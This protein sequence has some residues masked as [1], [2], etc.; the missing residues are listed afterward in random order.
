VTG[1]P[2]IAGTVG[3]KYTSRNPLVRLVVDSFLDAFTALAL[4]TGA[5]TVLE[6]GAGEGEVT[7]RLVAA[8]RPQA[9]LATD[10]AQWCAA[11]IGRR[12][13][14]ALQALV[15]ADAIPLGDDAV[16]LV[17][18]CEVLEHLD[19]PARAL[20]EMRR[21]TRRWILASVPREPLWRILNLA[22]LRHVRDLGNTPG[23]VRHWTRD[24]FV[25]FVG[26]AGRI[27]ATREPLP[28]TIALVRK[29]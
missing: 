25:D 20:A 2:V 4:R 6:V 13:P 11:E 15:S 1:K 19:D 14:G 28:W 16:D 12:A 3:D 7:R 24:G 5:R 9:F 29:A 21:V 22:R 17:V 8:L 27:E 23:H 10:V 26:A 18:A